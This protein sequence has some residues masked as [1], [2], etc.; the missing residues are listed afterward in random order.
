MFFAASPIY[1]R[2]YYR[3]SSYSI[4]PY[5]NV[6]TAVN[7]ISGLDGYNISLTNSDDENVIVI[8][9]KNGNKKCLFTNCS[10][11]K[12]H[13]DKWQISTIDQYFTINADFG[14]RKENF[15]KFDNLFEARKHL[16][17][18]R[19]VSTTCTLIIDDTIM[20]MKFTLLGNE[21]IVTLKIKYLNGDHMDYDD[22]FM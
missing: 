15:G 13:L 12:S 17:K 7:D 10:S 2:A 14:S 3:Y 5:R 6:D 22:I 16:L 21:E 18:L 19:S 9:Y 20:N 1:L 4:G 11:F 8:K